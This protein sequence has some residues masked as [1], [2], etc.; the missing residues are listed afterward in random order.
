MV[1]TLFLQRPLCADRAIII[2]PP[3]PPH[4][5]PR[6]TRLHQNLQWILHQNSVIHRCATNRGRCSDR[7]HSDPM[8]F[9]THSKLG[10]RDGVVMNPE[11]SVG[12]SGSNQTWFCTSF[13]L[14]LS[15][16]KSWRFR[17]HKFGCSFQLSFQIVSSRFVWFFLGVF[18]TSTYEICIRNS[19]RPGNCVWFLSCSMV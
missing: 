14:V 17:L 12:K 19:L 6:F 8:V 3:P 18:L 13:L 7:L 4:A 5:S 11:P 1:T 9:L 2:P 10:F 16:F 15:V